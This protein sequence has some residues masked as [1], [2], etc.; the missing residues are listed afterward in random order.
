MKKQL[1]AIIYSLMIFSS[2]VD[3]QTRELSSS[4]EFLDS[5]VALVNDGI[6]LRSELENQLGLIIATLEQQGGQMPPM[7][8][9]REDLLERLILQRVQLQRADRY[10]I[11]ITDEIL[12]N[13]IA[14]V[15]SNNNVAFEEFPG[16]LAL[17]GI[18]YNDYRNELRQQLIIDQLRQREV[19]SRIAVT[20]S[21]LN[22]FLVFQKEQDALNYDY[23]L[24]HILITTSS[25]AGSK[26]IETK[27]SLIYELENRITQGEDFAQ[28]ARENSGG[29]QSASGGNLGWMKGN[30]LPEVFIKVASQLQN[31]ELSQPF[32]TSSGFH[33]L[34][35]NQIKG[36]EPILEE[37]IQVRHI[38]IKTNE[39]LD[40]SAAEEKL[41]TIR[42][43]IIDEGNFGAVAA[44]VS[45]DVG[46]AQDGGDMGWAPRGFFVP[47]FEDVAYSLEKNEFSQPFRSRYG[48]H[49]IEFLGD[50]VYDNTEEI[51]RRKAI[52]AI[53]NSKLSSEIEIWA[54]EL[55][56]EAFVEILP[57]N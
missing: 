46:S 17:E 6:V 7:E 1:I 31:G 12:N 4:G 41:K 23:N 3:S 14:N 16:V 22:S 53:R 28:L 55:R 48:W 29:Q 10:G 44:A 52:S 32:Q 27:E 20:E 56:D 57:Y 47:E 18:D 42:Q 15:A 8:T 50:R 43:Q 11:R 40:D 38:L 36:N 24:S 39:V 19:I 5:V 45:E 9:I 30:Q 49:I 54:R 13:A 34:K 51:Q 35:L 33:L 37:Q 26:E 21:E 2:G 25:R